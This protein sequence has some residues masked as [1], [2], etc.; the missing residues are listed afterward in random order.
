[1]LSGSSV[2]ATVRQNM[3]E[4]EK[5]FAALKKTILDPFSFVRRCARVA[6]MAFSV[7]VCLCAAAVS[8]AR[9]HAGIVQVGCSNRAIAVAVVAGRAAHHPCRGL[10]PG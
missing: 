2:G 1:M 9:V 4:V 10:C 3:R 6:E 5:A 8:P 7:C